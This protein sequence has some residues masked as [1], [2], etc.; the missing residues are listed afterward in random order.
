MT[1]DELRSL[2]HQLISDIA[3]EADPSSVADDAD[4]REA[5]DLNS[6]DFANLEV[7]IHKR[8]G[9]NIPELDYRKLFTLGGAIAYVEKALGQSG[10]GS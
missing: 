2:L 8:T 5:F 1:N 6:M 3:P 7:A 9:A 4:I 10:S